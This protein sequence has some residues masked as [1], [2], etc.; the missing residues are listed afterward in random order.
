MAL[1]SYATTPSYTSYM[2]GGSS[3]SG[4]MGGGMWPS[5][6]LGGLSGLGSL[7]GANSQAKKQK[8]IEQ[9]R[10]AEQQR[11]Q[12]QDVALKESTLDPFRQQM[13]QARDLSYLDQQQNLKSTSPYGISN[14]KYAAL[15]GG[16]QQP[17]DRSQPRQPSY[18]PSPELL[19]WLG[20]LKTNVAGGQN[21]AP[22]MTSPANYG[23]TSALDLLSLMNGDGDPATARGASFQPRPTYGV[24]R[25]TPRLQGY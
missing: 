23:K 12:N 6:I 24:P 13:L 2:P 21:Q 16:G 25:A 3:S 8:E 22:T 17:M 18:T 4:G 5:L 10:I 11:S 19:N 14:A 1:D 9:M 20:S 7:F 15:V